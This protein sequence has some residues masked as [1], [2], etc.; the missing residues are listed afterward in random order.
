[1][2]LKMSVSGVMASG[3]TAHHASQVSSRR[4][5]HNRERGA[6]VADGEKKESGRIRGKEDWGNRT[7]AAAQ[8]SPAFNLDRIYRCNISHLPY[9][10]SYTGPGTKACKWLRKIGLIP[11]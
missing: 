9:K 4:R 10:L 2:N 7:A 1:M 3:Q 11:A 6:A 8:L 5:H